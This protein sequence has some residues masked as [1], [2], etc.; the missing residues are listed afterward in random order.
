MEYRVTPG[1]SLSKIILRYYGRF[2]E[3]ILK[4][5]VEVNHITDPNKIN[6]GQVLQL[7]DGLENFQKQPVKIPEAKEDMRKTESITE[8]NQA[9]TVADMENNFILKELPKG[10][11]FGEEFPKDMIVLHL[12]AG[13]SW[14][15]A[16]STF[17]NQTK[18]QKNQGVATPFIIGTKGPKYIVK[19]F[20]EKFWGY[21]LG[22]DEYFNN[23]GNDKRSIGIEI[24]NVGPVWFENGIWKDYWQKKKNKGVTL[25]ESIVKGKN[26]DAQGGVKFPDEQVVAVCNLVNYLCNKWNIKKQVPKDKMSFQ[27][28]KL[29]KF[30]GVTAHMMFRRQGKYDMGPAWPW[31]KMIELCG[32]EEVDV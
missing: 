14:E 24:T 18:Q 25:E 27:L 6:V 22:Q 3:Q 4:R 10:N 7:P 9:F 23:H 16:Y 32:L 26:R 12:T 31:N 17:L 20:D 1:D 2:N 19:L 21:H 30:K 5:V 11:Y 13:Y 29:N 8:P 15:G 28:P